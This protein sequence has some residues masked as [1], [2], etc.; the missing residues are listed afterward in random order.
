MTSL[1]ER[2]VEN[3]IVRHHILSDDR[4]VVVLMPRINFH[5]IFSNARALYPCIFSE[6]CMG[7]PGGGEWRKDLHEAVDDQTRGFFESVDTVRLE[8]RTIFYDVVSRGA[9][10]FANGLLESVSNRSLEMGWGAM[11]GFLGTVMSGRSS[12]RGVR[13][14]RDTP[15]IVSYC[16]S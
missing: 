5:P 8:H 1:P 9:C 10:S 16:G 3:E 11:V 14:K 15:P 4:S 13:V 12:W 7:G 2:V 6:T